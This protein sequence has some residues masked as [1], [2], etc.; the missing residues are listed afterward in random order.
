MNEMSRLW[1]SEELFTNYQYS[2][3]TDNVL[4]IESQGFSESTTY[5]W[6]YVTNPGID[7]K[8]REGR[9]TGLEEQGLMPWQWYLN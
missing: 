6:D 9:L 1:F 7:P 4:V 3:A 2:D 8:L 5:D